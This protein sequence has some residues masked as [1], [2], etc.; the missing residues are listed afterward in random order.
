MW[1]SGRDSYGQ[2]KLA[3]FVTERANWAD[4]VQS[5][6]AYVVATRSIGTKNLYMCAFVGKVHSWR[7]LCGTPVGVAFIKATNYVSMGE[8]LV[9]LVV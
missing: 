4:K 5:V 7:T 3:L 2:S 8:Q 1:M 9:H 6:L